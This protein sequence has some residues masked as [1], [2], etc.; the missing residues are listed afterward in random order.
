MHLN[1]PVTV[2]PCAD[3][4]LSLFPLPSVK[5]KQCVPEVSGR[6]AAVGNSR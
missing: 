2:G 5:D 6:A 1:F 4:L 3:V